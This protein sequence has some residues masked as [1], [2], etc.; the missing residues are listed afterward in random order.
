MNFSEEISEGS[1]KGLTDRT[2]TQDKIER[3]IRLELDES[4]DL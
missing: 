3:R 1:Y 2:R 4:F